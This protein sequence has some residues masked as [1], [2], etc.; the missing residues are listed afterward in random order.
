VGSGF[1]FPQGVAV[2]AS[3]D[4]F[5]GDL[6]NNAVKEIVAVNGV[7]SPSS[8]VNTVGSGLSQPYGVAVDGS[9]DVFVANT[10]NSAVMEIV[11]GT[12]KFPATAVGSTSATIE[13]YF[14]FDSG[15]ALAA[16]PYLVLTQGKQNSD[17][18]AAA[19]R[20]VNACVTSYAYSIGDICTVT[21]TFTPTRP[22]QRLGAVQLMAS[23]WFRSDDCSS[24]L[25]PPAA[26]CARFH[27]A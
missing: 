1:D 22:G 16:A 27:S 19:T 11:A 7:V 15:G 2:D 12:G 8:T 5:V 9:G 20:D 4:V 26:A 24:I 18:Q 13:V 21:V 17:F 14:T 25:C 3:G 23:Q 6:G 10:S